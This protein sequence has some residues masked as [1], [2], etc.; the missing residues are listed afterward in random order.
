MNEY[1]YIVVCVSLFSPH[2]SPD[3]SMAVACLVPGT[4]YWYSWRSVSVPAGV[5]L[6]CPGAVAVL[7]LPTHIGLHHVSVPCSMRHCPLEN[8]IHLCGGVAHPTPIF[9]WGCW[10]PDLCLQWCGDGCVW[11]ARNVDL[12]RWARPSGRSWNR[13][14]IQPGVAE[15]NQHIPGGGQP[16][17]GGSGR[18]TGRWRPGRWIGSTVGWKVL[19]G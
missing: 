13:H 7:P 14:S 16:F 11:V 4:G 5:V 15:H 10:G 12:A 19:V 17:C 8:P 9:L 18:A 6:S 1:I 2:V 3:H